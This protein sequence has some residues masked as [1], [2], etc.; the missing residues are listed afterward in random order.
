MIRMLEN[1]DIDRIMEIWLESTIKAHDFIEKKYWE[2][3]YNTVK[4]DYIPVSDV[5]VYEDEENIKG[6]IAIINNEFIGALFVDNNYQG[7]GIGRKLIEHTINLY[8]NLTLSVYKDNTKSVE[9]YKKMNFE[10]VSESIDEGTMCIEY[11]M[12]NKSKIHR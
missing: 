4:H 12:K 7:C 6:F 2:D 1:K 8:D 10:V 5:F 9:F 11:T 3:N